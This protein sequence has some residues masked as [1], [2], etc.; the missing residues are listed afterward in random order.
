[1]TADQKVEISDALSSATAYLKIALNHIDE[2]PFSREL[3]QEFYTKCEKAL[4]KL[5]AIDPK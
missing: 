3:T 4:D 5:W 2:T 1:M